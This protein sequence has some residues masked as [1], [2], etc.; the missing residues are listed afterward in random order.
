MHAPQKVFGTAHTVAGGR[1]D[2]SGKSGSLSGRE[3]LFERAFAILVAQDAH[4]RRHTALDTD[5]FTVFDES[6]HKPV[7][8]FQC[9]GEGGKG[10]FGQKIVDASRNDP[11]LAGVF[12]DFRRRPAAQKILRALTGEG[13]VA[14]A[15]QELLFFDIFRFNI[16]PLK[17]F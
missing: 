8:V 10:L 2:A 11:G 16:L 12:A 7:E 14:S 17:S 13:V 15:A 6:R 3:E 5:E 1:D 4:R 9:G